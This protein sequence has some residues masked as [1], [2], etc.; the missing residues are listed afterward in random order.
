M[1]AC[2]REEN[3]GN[4]NHRDR[5]RVPHRSGHSLPE[6]SDSYSKQVEEGITSIAETDSDLKAYFG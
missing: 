4:R 6:A 3:E 5:A 1:Y 2:R